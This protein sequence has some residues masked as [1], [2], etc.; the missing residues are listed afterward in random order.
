MT[1]VNKKIVLITG[2]AAGIGL[3]VV[4]AIA[5]SQQASYEI[6]LSARRLTQAQA[7]SEGISRNLPSAATTVVPLE[8]DV[9]SDKSIEDAAQLIQSR[10]GRI[11]VLVNNAG[12]LPD[13]AVTSGELSLREGWSRAWDINVT[14]SHVMTH[15][16]APLLLRSSDPRL[17]FVTS[18][19]STLAGTE[20]GDLPTNK[21]SNKGWPKTQ[22]R[23]MV[24]SYRCSK[25]GLN[26]MMRE[27]HR[28]LKDDGVKTW[29]ASPG[30]LATRLGGDQEANKK[31]GAGDPALGGGLIKDIIEGGRDADTG[32]VITRDGIQPW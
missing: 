19:T 27:W 30:F 28:M 7:A 29:A 3:E 8:I 31:M 12:L 5:A 2:A 18:S 32:K 21:P 9:S 11:D 23:T 22:M 15:T 6:L 20:N 24:P 14:A 17:L 16:F 1:V 13:F 10:Y 4:K 26:M 25:A